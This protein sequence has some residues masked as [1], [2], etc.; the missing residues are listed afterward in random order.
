MKIAKLLTWHWG[1]LENREWVFADTV[2]LTGESGSGKSTLLDAIQVVL[3]A[4][5]QHLVH[6]NIGQ[7]ESTQTRRGGKEPR[8]LPAYATGQQADGVFLRPQSTT[9]VAIVFEASPQ[10]GETAAPLTALVGLEASVEAQR[11]QYVRGP[12]F[13]LVRGALEFA[14]LTRTAP[15]DGQREPLPL[16]DL[17]VHLQRQCGTEA[18]QRFE[19]NK[20]RY[21]QHLYG[22]LMGKTS[23]GEPE[24]NRAA[25]SIV[26]AMAYKE[27]GNVN[28][29][30]RDEILEPHDFGPDLEKMRQLMRS[31]ADLKAE[32]ERFERNLNRLDATAECADRVL[33]EARRFVVTTIAHALRTR[34]DTGAELDSCRRQID[35]ALRRHEGLQAHQDSLAAEEQQ[36]RGQRETVVARLQDSDVA[37]QKAALDN[38][39]R[40]QADQFRLHWKNLRAAIHGLAGL[41]TQLRG[42]IVFDLT[43]LPEV[44]AAVDRLHE[45]TRRLLALWPVLAD[46]YDRD[47]RLDAELPGAELDAFDA[48]LARVGADIHGA[49]E[50]ALG[51]SVLRALT[52]TSVELARLQDERTERDAELR[53]LQAGRVPGSREAPR[54]VE[55]IEHDYPEARP[56]LLWQL[57]E[58]RPGSTWQNA[59]EGYMGGDRFAIIVEAG[60]EARCARLVKRHFASRS[61]KVVQGS[62]ALA[63]TG[64]R[65]PEA[66]AVLH[67]LVCRHPVAW[68]FLLAQYG[69]VRKVA[70]EDELARTSQ[71]LMEE[72]IGSRGYGMFACRLPDAELAFGEAARRRRRLACEAEL[73][74][75]GREIAACEQRQRELGLLVR[76]FQGASFV[77]IEPLA[78][79]VLEAQR[80]HAHSAQALKALDLS[81]IE[82]L[83]AERDAL[84]RRIAE[85][86]E[87]KEQELQEFGAVGDQLKR[88]REQDA[89]FDRRLPA[90]DLEC[91][92]QMTWVARFTSVAHDTA[93]EAQLVADAHALAVD[94]AV[95]RD[96]MRQ[97]IASLRSSIPHGM[98]ELGDKV[99]LYL[100]GARG[101]SERFLWSDAPRNVDKLE[102]LLGVVVNTGAAVAEQVRRQRAIGLAENAG[103]LRDAESN[104][105]AVFTTSFCFKVRDDVR[106]GLDTLRRLNQHLANLRFGADSFRLQWEWVPAKQKVFEFFEA[107]EQAAEGL[108]RERGS[109]FD[110]PLLSD[111]QRATAGQIR[112]W[113]LD[114]DQGSGERAL[115]ELADFRNYR[116][117]DIV[118]SNAVG[119]TRLSTWGTGSGGELETPFYVVRSA[120]LAHA[121]GHFGP[122]R[123]GGSALRLMLSDE[124]FSKMDEARSRSVLRFLSGTLGLQLVVAMPTAKS[125]AV[126]PEFDKEFTF[127]K[128][129]GRRGDQELF[130]SEVQEKLHHREPMARLWAEQ[131]AQSRAAAQAAYL[132]SLPP[133]V[134]APRDS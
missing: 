97:R 55:L 11:A 96:A 84:D 24:A 109:L 33:D 61:P 26:K 121:L 17:Y 82:A 35:A 71:G 58:P 5:R 44:A 129:Y 70:D 56:H 126:K 15:T 6:F 111:E 31:M 68:A 46:G 115:R 54:A 2:L 116:R 99:G 16:R 88:L 37:R 119:Q 78:L 118:R 21:L 123:R 39:V 20:G 27:L 36:L 64:G 25:R 124:A 75:L 34:A 66:Q 131:I 132:A 19:E 112:Q 43:A 127:S 63:D 72:G 22:A 8:T 128:V 113:L 73:A 81:S 62:K 30:V 98:R 23:V 9:Y 18:V 60:W 45:P 49:D 83:F 10:A 85:V 89:E 40:I 114:A 57:V 94:E 52:A 86:R 12:W 28:E 108:E 106:R 1:S 90:L 69:R 87:R 130:H 74:R 134:D 32:A 41:F 65:Q 13:F 80:Q 53:L 67:E 29:L 59:I 50:A 38:E 51:P 77:P 120:V 93:T 79:A 48:D 47:A 103:R 110:S 95:S 42:L 101:E 92:L 105:N 122:D 7:D 76:M 3:T 117:Y 14:Q 91:T 125:G 107:V 100:S 133:D 104:F 4:A 102:E